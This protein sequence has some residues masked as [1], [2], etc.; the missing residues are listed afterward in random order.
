MIILESAGYA[1]GSACLKMRCFMLET[2]AEAVE[3]SD[4]THSCWTSLNL[5]QIMQLKRHSEFW[6]LSGS[7]KPNKSEE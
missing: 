4:R 1:S 6:V 2:L 7:S 5:K 3:T